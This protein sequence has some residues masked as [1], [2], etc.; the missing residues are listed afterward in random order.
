MDDILRLELGAK[1]V[2]MARAS[3]MAFI[4]ALR[5]GM[6]ARLETQHRKSHKAPEIPGFLGRIFIP[7]GELTS[8]LQ[9]LQ[10]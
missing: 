10:R 5:H 3:P 1:Q 6:V 2:G 8:M 9:N 7:T 4:R